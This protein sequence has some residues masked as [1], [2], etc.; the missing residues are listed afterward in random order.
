MPDQLTERAEILL[1]ALIQRYIADGQPVGSR[2]LARAT[3]LE[4]S[5]ATVRNVMADLED[6]GM[7]RSPHTSAGRVPTQI[8]YRLFVDNMM[9]IR[10]LEHAAR[11]EIEG[12]LSNDVD[13]DHLLASASD[14]VS[15]IT[16]FAGVV[17]V[18]GIQHTRLRRLE[19]LSLPSNR[20]LAILIT[21][22]GRIQNRVLAVDRDYTSSEL[23]EA[24]NFFN[25]EYAD[26]PLSKVKNGLLDDM[27]Q[28]SDAMNRIVGTAAEMARKLFA[29]SDDA[30]TDEV[31]VSGEQNLLDVPDLADLEKLRRIFDTFKTKHDLLELLDQSLNAPGISVFIGGESGYNSLNDCSVVVAPYVVEGCCVGV[32]GVVGPTR[33]AYEDVIP[34]VDVTARLLGSALSNLDTMDRLD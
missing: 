24:S 22:D 30:S 9:T 6:M 13:Q 29:E 17:M 7:I 26:Q 18:P 4:L 34:V 3:G 25:T 15:Q 14:L 16:H 32:L 23:A 8:G 31:M 12:R 28:D 5:P 11:E 20:V 33:M 10:P 2:V 1:K 21:A 19:F 27:H